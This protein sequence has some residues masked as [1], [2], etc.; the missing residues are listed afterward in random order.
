MPL[1]DEAWSGEGK[2][3]LSRRKRDL[4][5]PSGV[6]LCSHETVQQAIQSHLNYFHLRGKNQ[7]FRW[8]LRDS[9]IVAKNGNCKVQYIADDFYSVN[10]C[11]FRSLCEKYELML[12]Y[13]SS[14][15]INKAN[16]TNSINAQVTAYLNHGFETSETHGLFVSVLL[17]IVHRYSDSLNTLFH[18]MLF[19]KFT[20]YPV[21]LDA[22]IVLNSIGDHR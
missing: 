19:L 12:L 17:I 13:F 2:T 21:K 15:I 8:L 16:L 7:K 22:I 6:K 20:C 11:S 3:A 5:F 9:G 1:K 14:I 18:I 10:G 4:L